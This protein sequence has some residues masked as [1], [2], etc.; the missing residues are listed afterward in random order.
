[1]KSLEF[2]ESAG[3]PMK[4]KEPKKYLEFLTSIGP[5]SPAAGRQGYAS[6]QNKGDDND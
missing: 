5:H 3:Y 6:E 1:M 4:V 2:K